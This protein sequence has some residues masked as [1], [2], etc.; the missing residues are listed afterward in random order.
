MSVLETKVR[1]RNCI[2]MHANVYCTYSSVWLAEL[3][4]HLI[5]ITG[6]I[7]FG[8]ILFVGFLVWGRGGRSW[9]VCCMRA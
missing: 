5:A 4:F 8:G 6:L 1:V 7:R 9:S 2:Y 3:Y